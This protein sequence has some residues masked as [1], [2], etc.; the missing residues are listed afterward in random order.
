MWIWNPS[1]NNY[2]VYNSADADGI[3]TNSVTRYIAPMQGFFVEAANDGDLGMSN[4]IRVHDGAGNWFKNQQQQ[5]NNVN[6]I[7]TSQAGLG[8]DE[9]LLEFGFFEKKN[10]ARKIFSHVAT[11]PSFY[12]NS[13]GEDLTVGYFTSPEETLMVPVNFTPGR[14]G[15]FTINCQLDRESFEM[16]WLEDKK[17]AYYMNLKEIPEYTFTAKVSDAADRFVLHFGTIDPQAKKELP[18]SVYF[19]G[20]EVVIDLSLVDE[21]AT[22]QVVDMSGRIL[23]R[24]DIQGKTKNKIQIPMNNQIILVYVSTSSAFICKKILTTRL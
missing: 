16:V 11:S 1:A 5:I 23:L 24:Q 15:D 8:S 12:M 6:L 10:G 14:D 7:V 22:V 20:N 2:G 9:I 17:E 3:G 13:A 18:A 21:H 4:S 19:N